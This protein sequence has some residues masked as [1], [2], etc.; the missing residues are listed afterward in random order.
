MRLAQ[1]EAPLELSIVMPCLNEEETVGM[2][3]DSVSDKGR[4]P[5]WF[6]DLSNPYL[7]NRVVA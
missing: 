7:Y 1:Q 5:D 3:A 6:V 2:G 4:G